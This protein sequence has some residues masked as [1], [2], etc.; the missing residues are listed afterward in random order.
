MSTSTQTTDKEAHYG[1]ARTQEY[2]GETKAEHPRDETESI[3]LTSFRNRIV[4][5]SLP[6]KRIKKG[7]KRKGEPKE[8]QS[9]NI[10]VS[11]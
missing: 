8:M 5:D 7:K 6:G 4:Y 1:R 10:I 11:R 9:I 3:D 2:T